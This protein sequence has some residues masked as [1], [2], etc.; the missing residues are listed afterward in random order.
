LLSPLPFSIAC[1]SERSEEP[2]HSLLPLPLLLVLL[3]P[4]FALALALAL[5]FAFA[6]AL[7]FAFWIRAGLQPSVRPSAKR[8]YRSAEGSSE[9][10]KGEATDYCLCFFVLTATAIIFLRFP[11]KKRMSSP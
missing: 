7:A 1:H 3:L 11:P 2:P 10:R 4:C 5:A 9:A 8:R 6:L